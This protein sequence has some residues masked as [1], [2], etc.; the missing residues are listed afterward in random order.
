M[1]R[2]LRVLLDFAIAPAFTWA[3][4]LWAGF[5]WL[6]QRIDIQ[7]GFFVALGLLVV[8]GAFTYQQGYKGFFKAGRHSYFWTVFVLP[9]AIGALG[10]TYGLTRWAGFL[11]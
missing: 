10:L 6:N 9:L 3:M 4:C 11:T 8:V 5:W 7:R 1:T 2:L